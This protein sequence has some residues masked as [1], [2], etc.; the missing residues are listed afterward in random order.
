MYSNS[1]RRFGKFVRKLFR[2]ITI[3]KLLRENYQACSTHYILCTMERRENHSL[4]EQNIPKTYKV[5]QIPNWK[6]IL[7]ILIEKLLIVN[8]TYICN[9]RYDGLPGFRRMTSGQ[10]FGVVVKT[11]VMFPFYCMMYL[12]APE[13]KTGQ[14]LQKPFVKFLVHAAS[15]V[16]FL[17][18]F[19][20]HSTN[21]WYS[22]RNA[23]H[24]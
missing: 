20:R 13:S 17:C 14:L 22:H 11:A 1:W 7:I 21:A 5:S 19:S 10:R 12:L 6:Y 4:R 16:F 18:E 2:E 9:R 24:N 3:A 15:Y 23:K 8:L